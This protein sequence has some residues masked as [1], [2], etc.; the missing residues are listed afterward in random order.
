MDNHSF[1]I[2]LLSFVVTQ[3]ILIIILFHFE[4]FLSFLQGETD[5]TNLPVF[6]IFDNCTPIFTTVIIQPFQKHLK[7]YQFFISNQ[8]TKTQHSPPPNILL[9]QPQTN[10]RSQ[11]HPKCKHLRSF[12]SIIIPR[13]YHNQHSLQISNNIFNPGNIQK[14]QH[15]PYTT[16]FDW[17]Q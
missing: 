1:N 16:L 5:Q 15:Y 12:N 8:L 9:R 11:Q 7:T 4:S 3:F 17:M 14:I 10:L 13:I 2:L 6:T